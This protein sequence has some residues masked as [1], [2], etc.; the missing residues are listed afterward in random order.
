MLVDRVELDDVRLAAAIVWPRM[1][2][3]PATLTV[4][5]RDEETGESWTKTFDDAGEVVQAQIEAA[6]AGVDEFLKGPWWPVPVT[7][8]TVLSTAA[9]RGHVLQMAGKWGYAHPLTHAAIYPCA[10]PATT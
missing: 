1:P 9:F 2:S 5:F 3:P 8:A 7:T 10:V 6:A 4:T